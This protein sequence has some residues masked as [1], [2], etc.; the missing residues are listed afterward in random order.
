MPTCALY[1]R[2]HPVGWANGDV[3]LILLSLTLV[4]SGVTRAP[5]H[6]PPTGG[7]ERIP[8]IPMLLTMMNESVFKTIGG[9]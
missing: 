2:I 1:V 8:V 3:P 5:L 9:S 6:G 7:V 4:H